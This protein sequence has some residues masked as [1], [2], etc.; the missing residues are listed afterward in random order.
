MKTLFKGFGFIMAIIN[1]LFCG[2]MIQKWDMQRKYNLTAHGL[3]RNPYEI[4][5]IMACIFLFS[6]LIILAIIIVHKEEQS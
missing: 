5:M 2:T 3:P 6:G 1:I 4:E